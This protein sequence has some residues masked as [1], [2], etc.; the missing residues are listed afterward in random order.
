MAESLL[1]LAGRLSTLRKQYDRTPD[2]GD[3]NEMEIVI[4]QAGKVAQDLYPLIEDL[5]YI[6]VFEMD[7]DGLGLDVDSIEK[8]GTSGHIVL[9]IK[10]TKRK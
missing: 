5:A 1:S 9:K 4:E 2:Q 8:E 7:D 10:T 3:G 6:G